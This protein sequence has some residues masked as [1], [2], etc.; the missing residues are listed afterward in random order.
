MAHIP[1]IKEKARLRLL[2]TNMTDAEKLLW[3]KLRRKQI[4]DLQFYR[5]KP[6][7]DIIVDFYCPKVALVIEVDGAQHLE[8]EGRKKD[9]I[10]DRFLERKGLLVLRFNNQEVLKEAG[11]VMERIYCVVNG[12]R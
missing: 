7:G 12:R 10:R 8:E 3:S 1:N 11:E 2:R 9:L 6:I 5:Q 4:C